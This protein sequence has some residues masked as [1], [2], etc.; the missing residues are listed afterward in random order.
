MLPFAMDEIPVEHQ[1]RNRAGRCW[2]ALVSRS[3]E[4]HRR[5]AK[6]EEEATQVARDLWMLAEDLRHW[7][8]R[9]PKGSAGKTRPKP[10]MP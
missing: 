7:I 1:L 8:D 4:R 9:Q 5:I 6:R 10:W 2:M 3:W